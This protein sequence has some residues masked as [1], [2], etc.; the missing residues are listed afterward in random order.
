LYSGISEFTKGYQPT[1]TLINNQ[2]GD[3]CAGAHSIP[4][5]W[6]HHT[7]H[8]LKV[9]GGNGIRQTEML[10]HTVQP[11][12]EANAKPSAFECE[13]ATEKAKRYKSPGNDRIPA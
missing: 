11:P 5:K 4:S 12:C 7:S 2:M 10:V 6:Q 8:L 3:L 9:Q 1:T 13:M